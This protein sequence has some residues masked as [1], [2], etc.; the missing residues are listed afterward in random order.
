[1]NNH[2]FNTKTI[3][4]AYSQPDFQVQNMPKDPYVQEQAIFTA[5]T[6]YYFT[7]FFVNSLVTFVTNIVS[8]KEK[9][10]KEVMRIMGMY[11]SAFWWVKTLILY[12]H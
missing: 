6:S 10:I 4:P 9:K 2:F 12:N 8:E 7:L 5:F 1:M 3:N 11:D